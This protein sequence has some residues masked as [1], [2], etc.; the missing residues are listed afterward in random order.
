MPLLLSRFP[1]FTCYSQFLPFPTH[2]RRATNSL[3]LQLS[4][5]FLVSSKPQNS[6]ILTYNFCFACQL[7]ASSLP[8]KLRPYYFISISPVSST[9]CNEVLVD[10]FLGTL[11]Y[12]HTY[13]LSIHPWCFYIHILLIH[14][15]SCLL[16]LDFPARHEA[17][18]LADTCPLLGWLAGAWL[19][20]KV[21]TGQS[22]TECKLTAIQT[23]HH[24]MAANK[25]CW[26]RHMLPLQI[27]IV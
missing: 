22:G 23:P 17:N 18:C 14:Y 5:R 13:M 21:H 20:A 11:E 8:F 19:L 2:P 7:S 6:L 25:W 10:T 9:H 16:F 24:V 12:L 3:P 15:F 4:P 26:G 27:N 1:K